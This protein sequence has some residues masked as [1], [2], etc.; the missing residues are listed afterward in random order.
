MRSATSPAALLSVER[1]QDEDTSSGAL[2]E[3]AAPAASVDT[4]WS[5]KIFSSAVQLAER[6]RS[7]YPFA[8]MRVS[9]VLAKAGD[10]TEAVRTA[11]L[12]KDDHFRSQQLAKLA[13]AEAKSG[14]IAGAM[15][16]AERIEARHRSEAL[17]VIAAAQTDGGDVTGA[18]ATLHQAE[19][20]AE[21]IECDYDL[22]DALQEIAVTKAKVGD[23][24]GAAE[25][26]RLRRT[27]RRT[28][29][30]YWER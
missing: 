10:L 20:F 26:F 3:I 18:A 9:S 11:L 7:T 19:Q 1:I 4:A 21:R 23:T 25:T 6:S 17:A 2:A 30:E 16:T 28:V 5:T 22:C 12:I 13:R 29:R 27:I 24:A 14:D 15:E 8:L